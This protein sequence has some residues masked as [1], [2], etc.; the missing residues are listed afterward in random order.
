MLAALLLVLAAAPSP[1][2]AAREHLAAGKL[3]DVLFD[4]D[5]KPLDEGD[6]PAAAEV[7]A[8]A[9]QAALKGNDAV[10]SLQ[11]AQ[12]A[13]RMHPTEPLAL[14]VGAR[15]A[16]AQQQYGPA[17]DYT[18]KW[19]NGS[20]S[21]RAKLLRAELATDQGDWKEGLNLV[22]GVHD[23]DLP[24]EERPRLKLVRET[25]EKEIAERRSITSEVKTMEARMEAAAERAKKIRP[26]PGKARTSSS[27]AGDVVVYGTSWCPHCEEARAYFRARQIAFVDKDVEKD[28]FAADELATKLANQG[29]RSTSVPWIELHGVLLK[30]FDKRTLDHMLK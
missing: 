17:E 3:D 5:G 19:L 11:F 7:L 20:H 16:R 13:L 9:G 29:K 27:L 8:K 22:T 30:G 15:A 4:L 26:E 24:T 1:L 6:K 10:L 28:S 23:R 18:D 2:A 21:P 14:E 25:C 12:M